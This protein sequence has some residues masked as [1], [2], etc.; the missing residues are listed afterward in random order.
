[1]TMKKTDLFKNKV[2]SEAMN[3][4]YEEFTKATDGGNLDANKIDR[5]SVV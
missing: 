5:K 2:L 4:F 1:M 3:S